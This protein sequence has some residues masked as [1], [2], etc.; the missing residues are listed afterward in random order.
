MEFHIKNKFVKLVHLV[1]FVVTKSGEFP[2]LGEA[3][4]FITTP[5]FVHLCFLI[6]EHSGGP[7]SIFYFYFWCLRELCV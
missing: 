4:M 2:L 1:G 3:A 5:M 6:T 7:W